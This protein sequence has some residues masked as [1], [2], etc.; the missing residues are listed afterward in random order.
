MSASIRR[1]EAGD[2]GQLASLMLEYIVD[3]YAC[4]A[5][6]Q[7]DLARLQ[8]R[9]EEGRIGCQ[10]VAERDGRL[11]GFATLYA[12]YSTLRARPVAILND[13]YVALEER[14]SGAGQALFK[15]CREYARSQGYASMSWETDR[16]NTKAQRF[17]DRMGGEAGTWLTYSVDL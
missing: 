7:N 16:S 13:L 1:A 6:D 12:S 5:P 2:R 8:D 4:P 15:A 17:Y 9:L 3:F 14:G 11:I 10:F